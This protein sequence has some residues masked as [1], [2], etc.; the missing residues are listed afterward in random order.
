MEKNHQG[1]LIVI[2]GVDGSG[3]Q[4]QTQLLYD[5][6]VKAGENVMKIAYPRYDKKSSALVKLYLE[7]AFG[8]DPG[9][10][11][12]YIASTFYAADR[13]ASYK[14]DYEDFLAQ[15]GLVL[16]DRYTTSNMVHQ[17]GKI[18]DP[19]ERKRFLDWLWDFEFNLYGLPVP[20]QVFFLNIPP[21][22]NEQLIKNRNNK[23]TGKQQKDI[24]ES[25]PE[26]LRDSYCSA[27]ALVAEYGWTEINCVTD[28]QLRSIKSIHQEIWER[29]KE[30]KSN[31]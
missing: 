18:K 19:D 12:P 14:E 21:E 23:I 31:D 8:K 27:L 16:V 3:K 9:S 28:N 25:S 5:R 24:H 4:T 11:S 2:E 13:Y 7:G 10:I 30:H 1:Q 20:D 29:I 6:L 26:H 15:G 17:A 22:I